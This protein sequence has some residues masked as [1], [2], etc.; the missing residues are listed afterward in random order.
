VASLTRLT[1]AK[2]EKEVL[3]KMKTGEIDVVVGTHR[4][5][6]EDIHFRRL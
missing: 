1:S 5:L 6:S 2:E 3:K 4:L